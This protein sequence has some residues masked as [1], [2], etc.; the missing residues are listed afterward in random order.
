M[1]LEPR[2]GDHVY[3][4]PSRESWVVRRVVGDRL[5]YCGWPRGQGLLSDCR[6]IFRTTDVEHQIWVQEIAK[7]EAQR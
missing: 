7:S 6:L 1:T 3:H 2:A 4:R 5:E